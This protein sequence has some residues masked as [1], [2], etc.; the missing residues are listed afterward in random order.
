MDKSR[1]GDEF[2]QKVVKLILDE[3]CIVGNG[4]FVKENNVKLVDFKQPKELEV[5]IDFCYQFN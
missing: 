2:V 4:D 5:K 1:K 3:A